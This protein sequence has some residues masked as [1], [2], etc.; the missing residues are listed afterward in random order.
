[1]SSPLAKAQW[2]CNG[3]DDDAG[4]IT[5]DCPARWYHRGVRGNIDG[6]VVKRT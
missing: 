5:S 1:M 4:W 2:L 3:K 6:L